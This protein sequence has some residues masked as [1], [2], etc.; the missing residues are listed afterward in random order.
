VLAIVLIAFSIGVY[1]L[2]S[3]ALYERVDESLR[4][5]IQV[6]S[7]S[8]MHDTEEGQSSEGAAQSTVAEL[9]NPQQA[10]AIF[11]ASGRLLAEKNPNDDLRTPLPD[12]GSIP[13]DKTYLYTSS[14]PQ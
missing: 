4:S 8:L 11:D 5:V 14:R 9:F 13:D 1:T 2:L 10:L 3:R 6:A 12:A 7:T